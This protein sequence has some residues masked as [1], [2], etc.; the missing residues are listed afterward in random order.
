MNRVVKQIAIV[1]LALVLGVGAFFGVRL[2]HAERSRSVAEE[3]AEKHFGIKT[4]GVSRE[5]D[6]SAVVRAVMPCIVMVDTEG[7]TYYRD[8]FGFKHEQPTKDAGTGFI[9]GSRSDYV[10]ILTNSSVVSGAD[11]IS[12]TFNDE[13]TADAELL[14][15]DSNLG[16][17]VVMVDYAALSEETRDSIRSAVIGDSENVRIGDMT[18]AIGNALGSGQSVTVGY[19][20]ALNREV[21]VNDTKRTLMQT[22]AAIN[23]G[24]IGGPLV[25]M[26]G[27]V[28]GVNAAKQISDKVEGMGYAIPMSEVVPVVER[29]M[30]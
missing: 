25:N 10:L 27:E 12:I 30:K 7:S 23:P 4:E 29:M 18:I 8:F 16:I 26:S 5:E 9:F 2:V 22:S 21:N 11:T 15:V 6:V 3:R 28:I 1:I 14:D 17:S 13:S 19:I 24:N 20:S